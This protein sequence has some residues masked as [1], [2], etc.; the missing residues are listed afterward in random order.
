MMATQTALFYHCHIKFQEL[1]YANKG[2]IQYMGA[3]IF[4]KQATRRNFNPPCE[5][6]QG[7]CGVGR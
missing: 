5:I 1:G 2:R 7:S 3:D 6:S 4:V